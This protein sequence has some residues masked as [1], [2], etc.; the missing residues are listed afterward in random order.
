[1]GAPHAL[2]IPGPRK[3]AMSPREYECPSCATTI[4][5]FMMVGEKAGCPSCRQQSVVPERAAGLGG[6]LERKAPSPTVDAKP[7]TLEPLPILV[8]TTPTMEGH[9]IRNYLGF[10]SGE[11]IMGTDVIRDIAAS[12][13]NIVGGRSKA[14]EGRLAE[15][16]ATAIREM[17]QHAMAI[18]ANAVVGVDLDCTGLGSDGSMLMVVATGTAVVIDPGPAAG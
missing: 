17:A 6:E 7:A 4:R 15:A 16:R 11:A 5:T 14:Y 13:T 8:V 12:F 18:G 3:D 9:A 1:M 2:H 10:V